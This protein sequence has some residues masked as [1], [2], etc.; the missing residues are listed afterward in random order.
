MLNKREQ[1][2]G[3]TISFFA[4]VLLLSYLV[5]ALAGF[6]EELALLV[7]FIVILAGSFSLCYFITKHLRKQNKSSEI[8]YLNLG[9]QR[10]ILGLFMIFYGVPK[11]F[12]TFFDYQLF[13]LDSKLNDVSEFE[14]AWYYFGKNKWQELF[15]GIMEF[16][17]GILLLSRRTYY[18]AAFILIPVTAQVFILNLFFKI[19]GVTFPAASILF[20]SNAYIIYSQK[21]KIK[22]FI[23]SLH[24]NP[25]VALSPRALLL[26]KA[27]KWTISILAILILFMNVKRSLFKTDF[28]TKYSSLVGAFTLEKMKKNYNDYYPSNDSTYY[29]DLY[30][31]K[32]SRWNILRRFNNKTE[33]FI[34]E[35]NPKN[36]SLKLYVNK[37]GIG[38]SK[39]LPDTASV[40]KGRY[41][42][43]DGKLIITG[44]QQS[45]TLELHYKKRHL[46]P[47]SWF[48]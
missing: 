7:S 9:T 4:I 13:A 48:W 34:M 24:F 28:Q 6:D 10:Y 29:K 37:G 25:S 36:D 38:D 47:K 46:Q 2:V 1:K 15:A 43:R 11:L 31:E 14:L 5:F 19:G 12:G 30:I 26:I 32:Q 22:Q 35:L 16:V 21:E 20:A 42:L 17:P 27:G 18:A 23:Q 3:T 45:D 41:D 40:L 33:A 44:I 8:D 39:D